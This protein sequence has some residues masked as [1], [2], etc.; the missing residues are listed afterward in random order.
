MMAK[1]ISITV[2]P[3]ALEAE[4]LTV[5][6]AMRQVLDMVGA[7]EGVEAGEKAERKIV[8]RLTEAHTNSPPFTITAEAFP[9]DPQIS[10]AM[11]ADRVTRRYGEAVQSV[12]GGEKPRWLEKAAVDYLKRALKRNLNGVGYTDVQIGDLPTVT[13]L[14]GAA[15]IG[16]AALERDETESQDDHRRTEYGSAEGEVIGITKYYSSPALVFQERLSGERIVCVLTAKLANELGPQHQWSEAWSGQ[17]LR[18]G[19]ELIYG[20]EGILKRINAS[21]CEPIVWAEVR[22][23][24][25]RK[26]DVLEGRT[27]QEHIDEFWGEE[28]G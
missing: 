20:P 24:D 2:H 8:W 21:Y 6:D 4:Y 10:I 25:L 28:F 15:R 11:E 16:L 27:V 22:L 13:I 14:P 26:A 1:S 9:K 19:G 5:S 17:H 12:L 3:S 23:S 7:L 18:V